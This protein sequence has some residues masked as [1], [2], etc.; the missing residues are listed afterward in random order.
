MTDILLLKTRRRSTPPLLVVGGCWWQIHLPAHSPP[1]CSVIHLPAHSPPVGAG[2][3]RSEPVGDPDPPST[4]YTIY[5]TVQKLCSNF[6]LLDYCTCPLMSWCLLQ[7]NYAT[8]PFYTCCTRNP[9]PKY[10][11]ST[12]TVSYSTKMYM[13]QQYHS[14]H[15]NFLFQSSGFIFS[16]LIF[17]FFIWLYIGLRLLRRDY[18]TVLYINRRFACVRGRRR[19]P[20]HRRPK[21]RGKG[22]HRIIIAT[23]GTLLSTVATVQ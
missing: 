13:Y 16:L 14:A 3:R 2:G 23:Y 17:G 5:S 18:S 4:Y 11:S 22:K 8:V 10:C 9:N 19:F 12:H 21:K 15:W 1:M 20:G 6:H 7:L